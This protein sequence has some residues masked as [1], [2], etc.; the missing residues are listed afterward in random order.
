MVMTVSNIRRMLESSK[1]EGGGTAVTVRSTCHSAE[2]SL[3][4]EGGGGAT[5]KDDST[6]GHLKLALI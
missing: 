2:V 1:V 5:P 4:E 6:L 3:V